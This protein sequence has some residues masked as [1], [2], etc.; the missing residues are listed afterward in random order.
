[1]PSDPRTSAA[2]AALQKPRDRYRS[3]VAA[4]LEDVRVYLDTHRAEAEDRLTVLAT[5]LGMVGAAHID[6]ARFSTLLT[7]EPAVDQGTHKILTSALEVLEEL[8]HVSDEA[9]VVTL[10][11]GASLYER[12]ATRLADFGRAMGAARVVDA[13]RAGR[14]RAAEHDRW[15]R[16]FPFGHW[17]PAE[18][19]VAPP[20]VVEVEG[21]DLRPAGLAEFLDG[22]VKMVLVVRGEASP[23]P[24]VR[25]V[26]PRTFVAQAADD[27][28]VARLAEW[29]GPGV[30]G[31]LPE[32]TARFSHSPVAGDGLAARLTVTEMPALDGR[33]R[34]GPF[35][36]AQLVEELEQL[37]AL[38]AA[39]SAAPTI[40]AGPAEIAESA[41]PADKLAA[42]LLQQTDLAGV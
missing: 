30:V 5:E 8:A 16:A 28:P 29:D 12:V 41:D 4:T 39:A 26:T 37:K 40:A 7:A 15:L 33:K 36:R 21:A 23:A 35:S 32:G 9:F 10:E 14:Y 38:Q 6:V 17:S 1:M 19:A 3:A 34:S 22:A 27:A 18:R 31:L 11:P 13:A 2:L 20:V 24:L 25:L 42:W